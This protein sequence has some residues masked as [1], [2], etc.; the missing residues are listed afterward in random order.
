MG[1]KPQTNTKCTSQ[2]PK[3]LGKLDISCQVEWETQGKTFD[4]WVSHPDPVE[5]IY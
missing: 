2:Q 1:F 5:N 4:R 3:D